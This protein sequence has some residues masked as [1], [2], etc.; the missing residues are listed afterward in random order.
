MCTEITVT[1]RYVPHSLQT[2]KAGSKIEA[3]SG[4][5]YGNIVSV[6]KKSGGFPKGLFFKGWIG[7]I[8]C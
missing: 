8:Q 7:E 1:R 2:N 4:R 6:S 3:T 5:Y